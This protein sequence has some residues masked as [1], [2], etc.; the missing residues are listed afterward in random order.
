MALEIAGKRIS[1]WWVVG[2]AAGLIGVVYIYKRAGSGSSGS[3]SAA[4]DS[5]A[6]DPLTGLPYS[7]DN[8]VD[9]VTGMTYLQEAQQYGSVQAAEQAVT[10][11]AG[12]YGSAAGAESGV[13]GVY[14]SGYPTLGDQTASPTGTS[15]SSNA[16]WAQAVTAGL[17]SIGYSS[18]DIAAALGLFFAQQPLGAGSDGV[19]YAS[20]IQ[21]A[22]AE[23]GPPPQ[24]TYS[25][26]PEPTNSGTGS[27]GAGGGTGQVKV[28][29][30]VGQTVNAAHS[31][32]SAAGLAY[33]ADTAK[34][35]PGYERKVTG[36]K[37]AAGSEATKGT[38]VSLSW[39]YVKG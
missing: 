6:I 1:G 28:P 2:G 33:N 11:G 17:T 21:A 12:Y 24:G 10:S 31:A 9:P 7:Q 16:Q 13:A 22:E 38:H 8:Q 3:S 36:Q 14:D 25:I 30:V 26:I 37:P 20:I 5:T 34:D 4:A 35:K 29:N 18:T 15:F 32:L 39:H 27:G 19:S 23:Y